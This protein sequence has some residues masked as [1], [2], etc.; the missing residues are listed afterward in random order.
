MAHLLLPSDLSANAYNAARYAIHLYGAEGNVFTVLNSYLVPHDPVSGTWTADEVIASSAREGLDR[1]IA[2]LREEFHTQR[3]DLRSVIGA[4]DVAGAVIGVADGDEPLDLVVMGTQGASGLQEVL[5]G[6]HT[7]D[8]IKRSGLPVLCVPEQAEYRVP[9]RIVLADDGAPL[10]HTSLKI[11]L[12]IARWSK[13]E[14]MIVRV[15]DPERD[16]ESES[17]D[18]PYDALLGAIPRSHHFVSGDNVTNALHD[19]AD[20]SDA[21]LVVVLHRHRGLFE[22]LFHRSTAARLAM[23]THIPMLVLQQGAR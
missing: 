6:T 21:D 7:A 12:D 16:A 17:S 1:F 4:G 18:S 10:E 14:V 11:L 13:A 22:Q 3:L 19:M 9:R 8:V 23:H 5:M 20:Q 2:D 15:V